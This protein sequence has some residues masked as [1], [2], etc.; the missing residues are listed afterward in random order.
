MKNNQGELAR[1]NN[2]S[3]KLLF[4]CCIDDNLKKNLKCNNASWL[5]E[6]LFF[7]IFQCCPLWTG[8]KHN[9]TEK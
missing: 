8:S 2:N 4:L 6:I 3:N 5:D 1:N 9:G 7:Y